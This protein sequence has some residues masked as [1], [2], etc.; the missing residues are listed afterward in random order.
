MVVMTLLI[1]TLAQAQGAQPSAQ[2][3]L[4]RT[5]AGAQRQ[6]IDAGELLPTVTAFLESC[7]TYGAVVA[8]SEEPQDELQRSWQARLEQPHLLLRSSGMAASRHEL[9]HHQPFELLLGLPEREGIAPVLTS[10]AG[11]V[12]SYTKCSG[13]E[14]IRLWCRAR[15]LE[16]GAEPQTPECERLRDIEAAFDETEL[17]GG[18]CD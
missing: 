9:L 5:G 17:E 3:W 8:G 14:G 2:L 7:R 18:N 13:L 10:A 15:S 12:T 11:S 6:R 16:P 1:A 4:L